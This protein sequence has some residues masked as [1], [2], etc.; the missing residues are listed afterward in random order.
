[1]QYWFDTVETIPAGMGWQ[2]FSGYHFFWLGIL[3]LTCRGCSVAYRRSGETGRRKLSRVVAL[4]IL[5]V[6]VFLRQ[7]KKQ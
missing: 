2:H 5:A 3:M 6:V 4:L 1:M 7:M